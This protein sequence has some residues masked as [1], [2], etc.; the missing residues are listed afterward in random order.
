MKHRRI[1]QLDSIR[2]LAALSVFL[3]HIIL[4]K[5]QLF[6]LTMRSPFRL[7]VNGHAAVMLFFILSGFVLSLP[8]LTNE[9]IQ[10]LP[11]IIKRIF[12]IYIPYLI[13]ISIAMLASVL[14]FQD[15]IASLSEW[16]NRTWMV[17]PTINLIVEHI[18]MI[19]NVH[20]ND[21]DNVI[22]SLIHEMRISLIFPFVVLLV[23]RSSSKQII[24]ICLMLSAIA[25]LNNRFHF[26][27]ANGLQTTYF[28]TVHYISIF[29]LGSWLAKHSDLLVSRFNRLSVTS[30]W[31]LF[32]SCFILFNFSAS[33]VSDV[34]TLS[35]L[36][37]FDL[38]IEEYGEALGAIG[39]IVIAM[40]SIKAAKFL[41]IRPIAFLGKISYS[42]YL[43]HLIILIVCVHLLYGEIP[44]VANLILSSILGIF[45]SFLAWFLIEN[46]CTKVGR[47]L[48]LK[49]TK[50]QLNKSRWLPRQESRENVDE[51]T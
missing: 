16:F 22:W 48:A 7:F 19:G 45:V 40:G 31:I 4:V 24:F 8:F 13:A 23:K 11:Y 6:T 30:K 21:F 46:P 41:K 27:T 25:V 36:R 38:I 17:W 3:S 10:Y 26:Q 37:P 35:I 5:T 43:Y 47:T 18:V 12:R 20:S 14:F 49:F 39:F 50:Y 9:K 34:L 42:L 15:R 1:E 28:D 32:S 2:G 51:L 44:L 29:I 33:I